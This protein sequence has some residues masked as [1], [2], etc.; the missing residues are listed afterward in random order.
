M[1]AVVVKVAV[2]ADGET[3]TVE[4]VVRNV[5]LSDN[6]IDKP[7]AG[8]ALLRLMV[9]VLLAPEAKDWGAH[10]SPVTVTAAFIAM[11]ELAL[12][13]LAAAVTMPEQSLE[14][15]PAVAVKLVVVAPA[16]I[17]TAAGPVS[18]VEFIEITTGRPAAGAAPL[19]VIVHVLTAPE[20]SEVGEQTSEVTV[21]SGARLN[22]AVFETPFN[23]AVMT[24]A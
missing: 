9:H 15:V 20:V 18:D 3:A 6:A 22:A 12:E 24:A 7:A 10:V 4:G 2:T 1:P 23:V 13:P 14:M 8:A 11:V 17:E 5:L 21:T 19:A 16:D